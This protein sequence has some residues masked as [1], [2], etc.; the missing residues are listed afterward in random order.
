MET[1]ISK[2]LQAFV[3]SLEK[4]PLLSIFL[5]IR[6]K[7][8]HVL[9]GVADPGTLCRDPWIRESGFR[10]KHLGSHFRELNILFLG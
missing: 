1:K 9:T 4:A 2:E 8:P 7:N 3:L 5:L 10:N 6:T